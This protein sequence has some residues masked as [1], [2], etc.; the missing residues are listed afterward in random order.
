MFTGK[1]PTKYK[2]DTLV[3]AET[4]CGI[5]MSKTH[6]EESHVEYSYR[7]YVNNLM[8]PSFGILILNIHDEVSYGRLIVI[9]AAKK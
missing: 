4:S 7:V 3:N 8:S 2:F 6:V 1:Q 9:K 5:L